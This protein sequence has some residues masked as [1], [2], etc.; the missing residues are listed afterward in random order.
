MSRDAK[1]TGISLLE[2]LL[3]SQA[4]RAFLEQFFSAW[5]FAQVI[6]LGTLNFTLRNI[7]HEF[8]TTKRNIGAM[9]SIWFPKPLRLIERFDEN[10][11]LVYG[12]NVLRF[13]Y[14]CV[15]PTEDLE[16]CVTMGAIDQLVACIE[17][18]HYRHCITHHSGPADFRTSL[19]YTLRKTRSTRLRSTAE[20]CI[21]VGRLQSHTFLFKRSVITGGGQIEDRFVSLRLI[22]C[23]PYRYILS[24]HSSLF[25]GYITRS[26]AVHPFGYSSMITQRTFTIEGDHIFDFSKIGNSGYYV[27][28]SRGRVIDTFEIISADQR[29]RLQAWGYETLELPP[30]RRTFHLETPSTVFIDSANGTPLGKPEEVAEHLRALVHDALNTRIVNDEAALTSDTL[31]VYD[32]H[33]RHY[34]QENNLSR[35][36]LY[37]TG[38]D[39]VKYV[40][41]T[42]RPG[43]R[44]CEDLDINEFFPKG[45][46]SV[47]LANIPGTYFPLPHH[48]RLFLSQRKQPAPINL[49]ILKMFGVAWAG[50]ILLMRYNKREGTRKQDDWSNDFTR[51]HVMQR[52]DIG[53]ANLV[54]TLLHSPRLGGFA[55]L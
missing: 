38:V 22:P 46:V 51:F 6:S 55:T 3:L 32:S 36:F 43:A 5:P 12:Q 40:Q 47:R 15:D 26:F 54:M 34:F 20:Q 29:I 49:C 50:N 1:E 39:S 52:Y 19:A 28:K 30:H 25:T 16:I 48:F 37:G 44:I 7:I 35:C 53:Y 18:Q 14:G 13:F 42:S 27:L 4:T 45:A 41:L 33:M 21:D 23:K 24:R 31:A 9:L 8:V 11:A 10:H 2:R 17:R